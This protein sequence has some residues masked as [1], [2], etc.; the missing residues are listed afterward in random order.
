[1]ALVTALGACGRKAAPSGVPAGA[2]VA[3]SEPSPHAEAQPPPSVKPMGVEI[4]SPGEYQPYD[5]KVT[6]ERNPDWWKDK[7]DS[8]WL[9]LCP[10]R[11][12]ARLV[13]TRML[14]SPRE[15][16]DEVVLDVSASACADAVVLI[17]GIPI[18]PVKTAV[19]TFREMRSRPQ[20]STWEV[21]LSGRTTT[22]YFRDVEGVPLMFKNGAG[23]SEIR[24][25]KEEAKHF[26]EPGSDRY[27]WG[28]AGSV[29][30]LWAGDLNGDRNLDILLRQGDAELG[31]SVELYL[32]DTAGIPRLADRFASGGC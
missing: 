27:D 24:N 14:A 32:S 23:E 21:N 11:D 1:L 13:P 8:S 15:R 5:P 17:R 3:P 29:K 26:A 28:Y 19:V 25:W 4:A 20:D 22:F 16:L 6:D 10:S 7:T 31:V 18:R 30:L 9:A 12:G 2:T